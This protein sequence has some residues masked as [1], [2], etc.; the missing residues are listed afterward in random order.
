[1]NLFTKKHTQF[2]KG[3][4]IL[5]LLFHHLFFTQFEMPLKLNEEVTIHQ[6]LTCITKVC[7][8]LFTILS[9]YGLTISYNHKKSNDIKFVYEH[10]KKL[11]INYWWIYVPVFVFSFWLHAGG[12]PLNIYGKSLTGLI[13]FGLDF[14][15]MSRLLNTSSLTNV[16]WYMEAILIYYV[17]FP[18]IYKVCNKLPVLSI[19]ISAT[20]CI[21]ISF[22]K[23]TNTT[24]RELFYLLPFV[25]GVVL[26]QKDILNKFTSFSLNK[27]KG[28]IVAIPLL[29][30]CLFITTQNRLIGNTLY[31][32]SIILFAIAIKS[33]S[34]K[35]LNIIMEYL[36]EYSMDIYFAHPFL[37]S[38]LFP[39]ME[40]FMQSITNP[41]IRY[42][43]L[44]IMSLLVAI[45]IEF[46]K[47]NFYKLTGK[48]SKKRNNNA[49]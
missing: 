10:I 16:W 41:I 26:A 8:A 49:V 1:M 48:I 20:P 21:I 33:L 3:I 47:K 18:V 40:R 22:V 29:M 13:K 4:A 19:I 38:G 35:P 39:I 45:I 5:L 30:V 34:I 2:I 31:A 36:G 27:F 14:F 44:V 15:G 42:L 37:Y 9:G 46:I 25:V 24:D 12:T 32:V 7:V 23:F 17:L 11:L 6:L 43:T 28:L